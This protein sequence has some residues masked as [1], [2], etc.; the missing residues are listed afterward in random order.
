MLGWIAQTWGLTESVS[1]TDERSDYSVNTLSFQ[2]PYSSGT[3]GDIILEGE[4][5]F[6][7]FTEKCLSKVSQHGQF[8]GVV[9]R[10]KKI[11]QV[12]CWSF[13][14]MEFDG[15]FTVNLNALG[16]LED[17]FFWGASQIIHDATHFQRMQDGT[18][19]WSD[20]INEELIAFRPQ[21]QF[22]RDCGAY[23]Q[24]AYVAGLDGSHCLR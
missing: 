15:V 12:D 22:L 7:R 2:T 1:P 23:Y 21:E 8:E 24:A 11:Q 20:P 19:N 9:S 14:G 17:D 5:E 10:L 13:A 6:V 3:L 18:F 4:S 16:Y